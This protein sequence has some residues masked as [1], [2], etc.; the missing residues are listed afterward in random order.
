MSAWAA[1]PVRSL[2]QSRAPLEGASLLRPSEGGEEG[3]YKFK[4]TLVQETAYGSLLRD[5]RMALHHEVAEAILRLNPEAAV[6]QA[7]VLAFH[8]SRAGDAENAFHFALLAGEQARRNYAHQ[9]A[10]W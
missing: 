10:K 9:E 1:A 8:Y 3:E 2:A 7:E 5:R 4:H 6:H